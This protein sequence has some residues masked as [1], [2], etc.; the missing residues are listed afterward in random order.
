MGLG[1]FLGRSKSMS[2][3]LVIRRGWQAA[4]VSGIAWALSA[5]PALVFSVEGT[6]EPGSPVDFFIE[7]LHFIA[8]GCILAALIGYRARLA[9]VYGRLGQAGFLISFL[10]DALLF[11]VTLLFV[12]FSAV[13]ALA[14]VDLGAII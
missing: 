9:Q 14:G 1:I 6:G 5:L 3:F 11:L 12:I 13:G 4:I 7:T 8:E 10:G 2:S